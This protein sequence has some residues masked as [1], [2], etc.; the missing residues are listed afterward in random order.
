[1][2]WFTMCGLMVF[3]LGTDRAFP[4]KIIYVEKQVEFTDEMMGIWWPSPLIWETIRC[5]K[6]PVIDQ[7]DWEIVAVAWNE[8]IILWTHENISY[9]PYSIEECPTTESLPYACTHTTIE[10]WVFYHKLSDCQFNIN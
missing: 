7:Y 10:E 9:L 1:M 5:P 4:Q 6:V 8:V 3:I 2:F